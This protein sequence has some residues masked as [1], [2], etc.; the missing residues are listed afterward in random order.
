ME[1]LP[2]PEPESEPESEPVSEPEPEPKADLHPVR[3]P[4]KKPVIIDVP[5]P[6]PAPA[7][8]P[9]GEASWLRGLRMFL[10]VLVQLI[11]AILFGGVIGLLLFVG[12]PWL[13][14]R[15]I[16]PL[17][18]HE[19]R[20]TVLETDYAQRLNDLETERKAQDE[21]VAT[22]LSQLDTQKQTFETGQ[23]TQT[24][25]QAQSLKDMEALRTALAE[26]EQ[27]V[28]A[29]ET[30]AKELQ[31]TLDGQQEQ[32]DQSDMTSQEQTA[33]LKSLEQDTQ[34]LKAMGM[35][36]RARLFLMQNNL[37]LAELDM[38]AARDTLAALRPDLNKTQTQ[39]LDDILL[40]LDQALKDLYT[41]PVLVVDDLEVAWQLLRRGLE[42]L[43]LPQMQAVITIS[44]TLTATVTVS[45][46]LTLE[47]VRPTPTP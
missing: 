19:K 18:Q 31:T 23:A 24:A 33:Q 44:P 47:P 20:L 3:L 13:N 26:I 30:G 35:L 32:L 27:K 10:K 5:D 11:I 14:N 45:P 40:R 9:K 15:F 21:Q 28:A 16:V 4:E 8:Q 1:A 17:D 39:A 7:P 37:G 25:A 38:E 2:I 43:D 34:L 6:V 42:P 12:I 29:L 36:S 41:A 22:L 46:T